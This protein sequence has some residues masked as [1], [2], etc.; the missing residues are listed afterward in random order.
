MYPY[1]MAAVGTLIHADIRLPLAIIPTHVCPLCFY[2]SCLTIA[3]D[4]SS[5][6]FW[7]VATKGVPLPQTHVTE[8]RNL[9]PQVM[10][11]IWLL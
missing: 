9:N 7:C 3:F 4:C 2:T 6:L 10:N 5:I 1:G 11:A 8:Y